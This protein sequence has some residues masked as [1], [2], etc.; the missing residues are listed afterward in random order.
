MHPLIDDILICSKDGKPLIEFLYDEEFDPD[1]L[2][3]L[4][5]ALKTHV[6]EATGSELSSFE[7]GDKKFSF[8]PCLDDN[9]LIVA[10]TGKDIKDKSIAKVCK[11]VVEI[12]EESYTL[13]DI[14]NWSGDKAI[15][16]KFHKKLNLYFKV[17]QL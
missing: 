11:V 15:F 1:L 12:F 10:K 7:I 9:V 2:S 16:D 17:S 14:K 4:C 8:Y 5:S 13:D 6:K 3:S